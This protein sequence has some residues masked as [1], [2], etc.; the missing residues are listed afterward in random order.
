M[1]EERAARRMLGQEQKV[2]Q[3][4]EAMAG[5]PKARIATGSAPPLNTEPR[6]SLVPVQ[7]AAAPPQVQVGSAPP[8]SPEAIAQAEAFAEQD[9]VV[10]AQ[11]RHDRGITAQSKAHFSAVALPTDPAVIDAL[12]RGTSELLVLLDDV[13]GETM[14]KAA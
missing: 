14:A 1:R 11:I 9:V 3:A 10:A 13:G 2:R 7:A 6:T 8:P 4:A 12:V 5:I